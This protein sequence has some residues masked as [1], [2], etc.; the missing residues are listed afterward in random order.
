MTSITMSDIAD[1]FIVLD[2]SQNNI[3]RLYHKQIPDFSNT[4]RF[5]IKVNSHIEFNEEVVFMIKFKEDEN[6]G[7]A[8]TKATAWCFGVEPIESLWQLR[9]AAGGH[10]FSQL[11]AFK[12]HSAMPN[13]EH[14]DFSIAFVAKLRSHIFKRQ[15]LNPS[16]WYIFKKVSDVQTDVLGP[17]ELFVNYGFDIEKFFD[18]DMFKA[19]VSKFKQLIQK[20]L[21][22][23]IPAFEQKD[24][25]ID[26]DKADIERFSQAIAE[27]LNKIDSHT[28]NQK[29]YKLFVGSYG[30]KTYRECEQKDQEDMTTECD[31]LDKKIEEEFEKK[32][33]YADLKQTEAE[34][35]AEPEQ[36]IDEGAF[37]Y[38]RYA[39]NGATLTGKGLQ[40]LIDDTAFVNSKTEGVV[41]MDRKSGNFH[42]IV[43]AHIAPRNKGLVLQIDTSK[44]VPPQKMT[45]DSEEQDK[46]QVDEAVSQKEHDSYM[47]VF[48]D[49][50]KQ[51]ADEIKDSPVWKERNVESEEDIIKVI[52]A[53]A[54]LAAY[55][56]DSA[57]NTT[58]KEIGSKTLDVCADLMMH[59]A[60]H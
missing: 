23:E 13:Q 21:K 14:P 8:V 11:C 10:K 54:G 43:D 22:T 18:S 33:I 29:Y 17:K 25:N 3:A 46:E 59:E 19:T 20:G 56:A 9:F 38:D 1:E 4:I 52:Y 30:D 48:K 26:N 34:D 41:V 36:Q 7:K 50:G 27:G 42:N 15:N 44:I 2:F 6:L 16:Q 5:G 47:N 12:F 55:V 28:V 39:S 57:E 45:N 53:I 40:D 60:R 49:L 24:K 31:E 51:L 37:N 58:D 35:D 32:G